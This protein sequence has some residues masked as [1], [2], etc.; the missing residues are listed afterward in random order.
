[1]QNLTQEMKSHT[2]VFRFGFSNSNNRHK[3]GGSRILSKVLASK[4]MNV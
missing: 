4:H 3:M 2:L 1:L